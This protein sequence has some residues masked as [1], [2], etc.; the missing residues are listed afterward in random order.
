VASRSGRKRPLEV[1]WRVTDEKADKEANAGKMDNCCKTDKQTRALSEE[2]AEEAKE[3]RRRDDRNGINGATL[4]GDG[5]MEAVQASETEE[6]GKANSQ[7]A[8][9]V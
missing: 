6:K 7:K 8:A 2:H 5:K 4:F 3:Q 1:G 9:I